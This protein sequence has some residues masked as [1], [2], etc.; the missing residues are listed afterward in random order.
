MA[1]RLHFAG[2]ITYHL[3]KNLMDTASNAD[4]FRPA[5][6][7]AFRFAAETALIRLFRSVIPRLPWTVL[8]AVGDLLGLLFYHAAG[9]RRRVAFQNLELALGDRFS[10][11]QREALAL[12]SCQHVVK[13]MLEFVRLPELSTADL[14]ARVPFTGAEQLE[15][16]L[17]A[18]KGAIL[19]T[20]HLGNWEFMAARVSAAGFPLTVVGRD[21]ANPAVAEFVSWLRTSAGTRVLPKRQSLRNVLAVLRENEVLGI[22]PDQHAGEGGVVHPFFGVPTPMH[23]IPALLARRTGAP[24]VAGAATR[25]RRNRLQLT[26]LPPLYAPRTDDRKRDVDQCLRQVIQVME[27]LIRA[28]PDQ[29]LWIHKRWRP[30]SDG[31]SGSKKETTPG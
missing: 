12:R 13:T 21:A 31:R 25:D 4:S 20:P 26:L 15:A 11:A 1:A 27:Q 6:Q 29:W 7:P 3:R 30:E 8:Y 16:A 2:N 10:P 28:H 5:G 19:I 18:G 24:L 23:A 22:L 14:T 17:N 9:Q